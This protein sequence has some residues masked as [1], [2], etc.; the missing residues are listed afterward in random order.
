MNED[1]ERLVRILRRGC[2]YAAR[3]DGFYVWD[4]DAG[5]LLRSAAALAAASRE[6][7]RRVAPERR[8]RRRPR[9]A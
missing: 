2:G 1:A 3:G 8:G 6:R 7:V 4:E 9:L 5:E